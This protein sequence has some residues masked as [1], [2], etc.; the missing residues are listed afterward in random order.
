MERLVLSLHDLEPESACP[1][2]WAGYLIESG[3]LGDLPVGASLDPAGIFYWQ[4]GPGF[5]GRF[6]LLF[7]RTDCRAAKQ[8]LPVTVTVRLP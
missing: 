6:D 8:R 2:T 1:A 3:V 4:T 7:V 5:A